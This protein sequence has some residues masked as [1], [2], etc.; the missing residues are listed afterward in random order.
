MALAHNIMLRSLNAIYLQ[1]PNIPSHAVPAFIT[2]CQIFVEEIHLHH[3][4]EEN[5]LF[6]TLEEYVGEKGIMD[7]NIEQHR[8]FDEGLGKF[9]KYLKGVADGIGKEGA[10][11]FD[12]AKLSEIIDGFGPVVTTH[13]TDEIPTL[14]GLERFGE[15]VVVK[16]WDELEAKVLPLIKDKVRL[17]RLDFC[18]FM[19]GLLVPFH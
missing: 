11:E 9:E 7:A 5:I 16:A 3:Q 10:E 2:F 8:A 19:F 6:P 18:F 17:V 15:A 13:L 14:L 12:G 4:N 1:A